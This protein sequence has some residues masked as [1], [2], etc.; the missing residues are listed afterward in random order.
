MKKQLVL[1]VVFTVMGFS[2]FAR[3]NRGYSKDDNRGNGNQRMEEFLENAEKFTGSGKLVL[4]NGQM[5]L[6]EV[7]G[8]IYTLCAPWYELR[9]LNL[10]DGMDVVF[11]G[12]EMPGKPMIWDNSEKSIMLTKIIINGIE[13]EIENPGRRGGRG[14]SQGRGKGRQR[15]GCDFTEKPE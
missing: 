8:T 5:P 12:Y 14:N 13:T 1:L 9:E 11:E 15:I 6:V 2:L 10:K 4:E 7:D 3:D